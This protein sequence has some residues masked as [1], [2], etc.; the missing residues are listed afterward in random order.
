MA[1]RQV[2]HTVLLTALN[3][4]L[5]TVGCSLLLS[6]PHNWL[7]PLAPL[8]TIGEVWCKLKDLSA[9]EESRLNREIQGLKKIP[10]AARFVRAHTHS[11]P[12]VIS[13]THGRNYT[14][15]AAGVT[16]GIVVRHTDK[17]VAFDCW[18]VA[19]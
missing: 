1:Q 5:L 19:Q 7:Q 8:L 12:G 2:E 3:W 9:E 11:L 4:V 15:R 16:Y 13:L 14:K 6:A 18:T 10:G 17:Q